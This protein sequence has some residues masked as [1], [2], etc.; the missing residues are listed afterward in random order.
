MLAATNANSTKNRPCGATFNT[1]ASPAQPNTTMPAASN[2]SADHRSSTN[3][4]WFDRIV[5]SSDG[6]RNGD[7]IRYVVPPSPA[8]SPRFC[9][10][11]SRPSATSMQTVARP[12]AVAPK[13]LDNT[14]SAQHPIAAACQERRLVSNERQRHSTASGKNSSAV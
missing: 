13:T 12:S 9:R 4:C 1:R 14:V 6:D 5:A 8:A 3:R 10:S 2:D 11:R 7:T